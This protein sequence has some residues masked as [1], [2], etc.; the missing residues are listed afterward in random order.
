[1]RRQGDTKCNA[2]IV[3]VK[4]IELQIVEMVVIM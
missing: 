1:M 2:Q 4:I 3:K